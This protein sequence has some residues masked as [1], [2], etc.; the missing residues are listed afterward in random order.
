MHFQFGIHFNWFELTVK[1][2]LFQNI[3]LFT[4]ILQNQ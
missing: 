2:L 1:T 3:A 4:E